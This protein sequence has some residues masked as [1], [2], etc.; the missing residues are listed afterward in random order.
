MTRLESLK[1]R[2][3]AVPDPPFSVRYLTDQEVIKDIEAIKVSGKAITQKE[4]VIFSVARVSDEVKK[5][6]R[7]ILYKDR[8]NPGRA[9]PSHIKSNTR[10]LL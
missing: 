6:L 10:G 1:K 7:E 3:D 8:F 5:Q 9:I 2:V 4:D